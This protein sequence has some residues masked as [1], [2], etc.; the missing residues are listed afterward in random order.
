MREKTIK[1]FSFDELDD[2]AKDRARAWYRDGIETDQYA[3]SVI[4]DAAQCAEI[5]GI[6]LRTRRVKLMG[7]GTRLEPAVYWSGFSS[8]G[9]GACF[10]GFY[11]YVKGAAAKIRAHA[12][13][14]TDLHQIAD[15]LQEVQRKYFYRLSAESTHRG[16]YH[17]SG[18]MQ[19]SVSNDSNR[20][21]T[22]DDEETVRQA[23]REF[24]DWIYGNLEKEYEYQTA[25]EQV[26]ESIKANEYEFDEDGGIA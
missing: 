18:T 13:Q 9:D 24:A 1:L 20:E 11:R 25:D 3:E 23:L 12:P 6:D 5:I 22:T 10:E 4:E 16:H 7:G 17:H 15:D 21:L 8:Q 2:R 14:D 26:D 19:I